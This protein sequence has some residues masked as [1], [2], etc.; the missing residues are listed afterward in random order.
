MLAHFCEQC[1][2]LLMTGTSVFFL[3]FVFQVTL[4]L[5]FRLIRPDK[6]LKLETHS[7]VILFM[8]ET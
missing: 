1:H 4:F 2:N 8:L 3:V 7:L 6:G 5:C